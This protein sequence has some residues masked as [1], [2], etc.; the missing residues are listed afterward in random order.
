MNGDP[1]GTERHSDPELPDSLRHL[2]DGP[3]DPT[4]PAGPAEIDL[5]DEHA[6]ESAEKNTGARNDS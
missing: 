1:T 2:F 5:T 4:P 3:A 6:S